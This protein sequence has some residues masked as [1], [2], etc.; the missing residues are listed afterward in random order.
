MLD[1]IISRIFRGR[2]YWRTVSFDEVAE[3]YASRLITVFAINTINLFAAVYLYKLG[4]S[5]VF[6]A[7]FYALFYAVRTPF[8]LV[9]AKYVA[10]FGPKHGILLANILRI[11]SLIAFAFV[12]N[13]SDSLIYIGLFG[14]FQQL[15]ATVYDI[16][17]AVDFSKVKHSEHAGREIGVMQ[18]IEKAARVAS[19]LVGGAVASVWSPQVAIVIASGLFAVAAIPLFR[20]I[21]P[22]ATRN[23]LRIEGFPWRLAAP[24]L[25]SQTV[26]GVDFIASGLAW[27]LFI[28]VVVFTNLG[29]NLYAALGGLSSI[30]V[31]VSIAAAWIFGRLIDRH[32]GDVLLVGGTLMNVFVHVAR[33]FVSTPIGVLTTNVLN[34]TATSAYVMPFTRVTFDIAD[35]SGFR[36]TYFMFSEMM[37]SLGAMLGCLVLAASVVVGGVPAGFVAMFFIAAV[38]ELLM[39]IM[40]RAAR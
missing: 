4:Y 32:H 22:T 30:G 25:I 10:Y 29:S 1:R 14:L 24:T 8:S 9:A 13:G 21:E 31:L 27:T 17:Y 40:T 37:L 7:L 12:G 18:Q 33:P 38:Y 19:P 3:L 15:S 5:L 28:T 23:R 34:E 6:I 39:L 35:T 16:S 26:V 11:P 2:H 36:I 20:T